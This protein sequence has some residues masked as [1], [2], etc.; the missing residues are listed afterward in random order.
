MQSL[1][2]AVKSYH[3]ILW[4]LVIP[5]LDRLLGPNVTGIT[6]CADPPVKAGLDAKAAPSLAWPDCRHPVTMRLFRQD[7]RHHRESDEE[8]AAAIAWLSRTLGPGRVRG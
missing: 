3:S 8:Q 7:W 1:S 4:Q 6:S 5:S 2:Q